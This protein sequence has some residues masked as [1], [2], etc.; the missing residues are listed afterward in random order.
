[1]RYY[2]TITRWNDNRQFGAIREESMGTEVFAPLSAFTTLTR[3]PAEGQRVSFDIVKGRRGRDEAE[4]ICFSLDC[5]DEFDFF[6]TEPEPYKKTFSKLLLIIPIIAL[7]AG[8]RL[9]EIKDNLP[10]MLQVASRFPHYQTVIAGA[11]SIPI[12]YYKQFIGESNALLVQN[13]TYPLL[14]HST[15]ALVTSGTATLETALFSVPQVVCYQTPFPRLIR[16]AFNHFIGVK[17]I[18]LVNLIADREVVVELFADRF[19]VDSIAT[20]LLRILPGGTSR[21]RMLTDYAH[22]HRLLGHESAPKN[23]ARRMVQLL[24]ERKRGD[25]R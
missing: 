3:P 22:L 15:A 10:T 14:A 9:Q 20:E 4:N 1:M 2:G 25:F 16:F 19:S 17:Y 8:S 24:Q 21:S 6:D 18:S 23:A 7:L 13:E 11:P 5:V 12:E